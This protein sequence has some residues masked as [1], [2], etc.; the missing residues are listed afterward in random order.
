MINRVILMGRLVS[1]PD[2]RTTSSGLSVASFRLAVD[3]G[4]QRGDG[5]QTADF[6]SCVAWRQ[7]A[8]FIC[9][10]FSK[11]RMIALE[12]KLQSRSYEDREGN[13]RNVL[14]VVVDQV[15]FTGEKPLP[16]SHQS[17]ERGVD[18]IA[19]KWAAVQAPQAVPVP[20]TGQQMPLVPQRA[21]VPDADAFD[22]DGDLPF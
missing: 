18:A 14:E 4:Y 7:T 15:S 17:G 9:N 5:G 16:G 2:K 19:D 8:D 12:G 20:S 6:I 11:G 3:R 1:D 21:P 10:Y 22:D 13:K